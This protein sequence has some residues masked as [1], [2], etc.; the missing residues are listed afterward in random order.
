MTLSKDELIKKY[1]IIEQ[2]ANEQ[3]T[4][5]EN[6]NFGKAAEQTVLS[7][8]DIFD[9]AARL[10]RFQPYIKAAFSETYNRQGRLESPLI[11]IKTTQQNLENLWQHPVAGQLFVKADHQ[12][13]ISGTIQDRGGLYAVLKIA[14]DIA[15]QYSNLAYEDDYAML[16]SNDFIQLFNHFEIVTASNG[17]LGLSVG[18]IAHKLGFKVTVYLP[19]HTS[20]WKKQKLT[21]TGIQVIEAEGDFPNA[22]ATAQT[23]AKNQDNTLFIDSLNDKEMLAGHST[24][25]LHFQMQLKTQNI[26][27]DQ[28]HPLFIYLPADSGVAAAGISYSLQ[29]IF[30]S[31]VYPILI[32]S[33]HAPALT[34][35]L[36]TATDDQPSVS[37]IGLDNQT[38]ADDLTLP[39]ASPFVNTV[40]QN[41]IFAT[42]TLTDED[43]LK[44]VGLLALN[45]NIL[46]EPA[47]AGG[48]GGLAQVLTHYNTQFNLADATHIIW[49]TGGRLV[50]KIQ[51]AEYIKKGEGYLNPELDDFIKF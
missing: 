26:T 42:T 17:N 1:P 40:A 23:Y 2:L 9:A 13:P 36:S 8:I 25:A 45:E 49:T 6:T 39:I 50:P 22:L 3:P 5:W 34:L 41:L 33:T 46:T 29:S 35:A 4:F 43:F 12:L 38:I 18:I 28:T 30:G 32:E 51:M 27:V 24:A 19:K 15:M 11:Q 48:F 7:K 44:Y 10:Q 37:D 16:A 20:D 31:N 21:E 47:A 14:E